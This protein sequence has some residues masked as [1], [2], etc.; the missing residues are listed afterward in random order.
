VQVG[1]PSRRETPA[2]AA[3]CPAT[4][5]TRRPPRVDARV[6]GPGRQ[7]TPVPEPNRWSLQVSVARVRVA[8]SGT[9]AARRGRGAA[10]QIIEHLESE[11]AL[12]E[13]G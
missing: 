4:G 3:S 5:P 7:H 8:Q 13:L 2:A 9:P 6:Q 12:S 10:W 11:V 1:V